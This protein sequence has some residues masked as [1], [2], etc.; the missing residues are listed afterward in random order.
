MKN[1]RALMNFIRAAVRGGGSVTASFYEDNGGLLKVS[2][3]S[4]YMTLP[5]E[6]RELD[7]IKFNPAPGQNAEPITIIKEKEATEEE[8]E[9]A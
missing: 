6:D 4:A 3:E 5:M 7:I 8:R 2:I 1:E 9:D